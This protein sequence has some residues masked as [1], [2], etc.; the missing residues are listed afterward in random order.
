MLILVVLNLLPPKIQKQASKS[1]L[2]LTITASVGFKVRFQIYLGFVRGKTN[3]Q[4]G[5][6]QYC[7]GNTTFFQMLFPLPM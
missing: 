6:Q 5:T 2:T 7:H 4:Y 3:M 1:T